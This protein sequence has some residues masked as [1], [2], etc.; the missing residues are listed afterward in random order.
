MCDVS[1]LQFFT[2]NIHPF[3]YSLAKFNKFYRRI[4]SI[5]LW[6]IKTKKR[7]TAHRKTKD[8][9]TVKKRL[10][11]SEAMKILICCLLFEEKKVS[12]TKLLR[13][14]GGLPAVLLISSNKSIS[15]TN[16]LL[17]TISRV[18]EKLMI[19]SAVE[20]KKQHLFLPFHLTTAVADSV[21]V[22]VTNEFEFK[23][24]S[25]M[26]RSIAIGSIK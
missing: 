16:V 14:G 2:V 5:Y 17:H 26:K 1:V 24:N 7:K 6:K 25:K 10:T 4:W 9:S 8:Q 11:S 12:Q 20:R 15:H 23:S 19:L 3:S 13:G 18:C 21:V 22:G